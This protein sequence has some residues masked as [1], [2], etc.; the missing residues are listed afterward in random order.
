MNTRQIVAVLKEDP[1][2]R[3]QFQGVFPSDLLPRQIQRYP[4]AFVANVDPKGQPGSHWCAFY[5]TKDQKGEFFDSYGLR[6][7]DY[8]QAFQDFLSNSSID[9]T[10]NQK[11][12]QGLDS[13][14]CG[15]Y[16][17]YF[18]LN[19]CRNVSMKAIL[20]RF[21]QSKILN[22]NFVYRFIVKHFSRTYNHPKKHICHQTSRKKNKHH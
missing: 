14:V 20:A 19:R 22:D 5:F 12:L 1:F 7:Q 4:A 2:T 13:N 17:L 16:C 21:N 15:H 10:Y 6:P 8:T 9:W 3:P 11:C 18:L